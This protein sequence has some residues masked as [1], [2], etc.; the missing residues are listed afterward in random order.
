MIERIEAPDAPDDGSKTLPDEAKRLADCG[1]KLLEAG[2]GEEAVA[3]LRQA[4]A[5]APGHARTRSQLGLAV[6]RVERCF[7]EAQALCESAARQEFFNPEVYLNLG[8]VYLAFGLRSEGM[9]YLRRGQMI[10]PGH[11]GIGRLLAELGRR[12]M[13]VV[14]FLP[15]RHPLNRVLGSAR[16]LMIQRLARRHSEGQPEGALPL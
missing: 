15:R 13:P 11:L 5:L 4:Y 10:D 14:P 6:A 2:Q 1:M 8:L 12:R 7:G 9:R 3:C 16:S